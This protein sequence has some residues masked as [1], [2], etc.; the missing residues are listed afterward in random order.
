MARKAFYSKRAL[1]KFDNLSIFFGESYRHLYC[2]TQKLRL[3]TVEQPCAFY[4]SINEVKKEIDVAAAV[5]IKENLPETTNV[6]KVVI[7]PSEVL[8]TTH[9]GSYDDMTAPYAEMDKYLKEH[10]FE[11]ELTIEEYF[12]DPSIEKDS[13][14]WKTNIYFLLK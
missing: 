11:K 14:K 12:T 13:N 10:H 6:D 8:M 7:T 2:I 5:P 1:V 4:Y 3:T 9:Y